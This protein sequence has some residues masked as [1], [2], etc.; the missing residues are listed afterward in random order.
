MPTLLNKGQPLTGAYYSWHAYQH[1]WKP[2]L[3]GVRPWITTAGHLSLK[4]IIIHGSEKVLYKNVP[5]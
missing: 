4:K 2:I 5:M 1:A 3:P